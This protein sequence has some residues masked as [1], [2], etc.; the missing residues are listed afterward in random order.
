MA[1]KA[2]IE[3]MHLTAKKGSYL[4]GKAVN[5]A[6]PN[7]QVKAREYRRRLSG[8]MRPI[9]AHDIQTIPK[10][11]S[12]YAIRKYDGEFAYVVFD[13]ESLFSVNPGGTVRIGLPCFAE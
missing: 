10:A 8:S 5:L 6:D 1:T 4:T 9:A 12:I 7:W 13:G 2:N 11:R 3:K